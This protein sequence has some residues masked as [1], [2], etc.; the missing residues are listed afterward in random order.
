LL[1]R[2]CEWVSS[3]GV[4]K[5][6]NGVLQTAI[7]YK[8]DRLKVVVLVLEGRVQSRC[9]KGDTNNGAPAQENIP[10]FWSKL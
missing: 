3:Q 5:G 8:W 4:V 2:W 7:H 1:G 6:W 9:R 10:N